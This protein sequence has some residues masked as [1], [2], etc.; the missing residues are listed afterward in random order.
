MENGNCQKR[1]KR[2][3]L[4]LTR[5]QEVECAN[6]IHTRGRGLWYASEIKYPYA[7]L[8]KEFPDLYTMDML[9]SWIANKEG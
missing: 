4:N 7:D 5:L 8:C 2:R 3:K 1:E 9:L 6:D